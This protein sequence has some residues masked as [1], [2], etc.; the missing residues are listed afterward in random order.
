MGEVRSPGT[1]SCS[2]KGYQGMQGGVQGC[3]G[4]GMQGCNPFC[5]PITASCPITE[6]TGLGPAKKITNMTTSNTFDA[7]GIL[8]GPEMPILVAAAV[9][10]GALARQVAR[11]D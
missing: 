8:A 5:T 6:P 10:M 7:A 1:E 9:P 2:R 3:R 11:P 4:A